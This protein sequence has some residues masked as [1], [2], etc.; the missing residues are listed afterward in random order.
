MRRGDVLVVV[1]YGLRFYVLVEDSVHVEGFGK[2]SGVLGKGEMGWSCVSGGGEKRQ[3]EGRE[4]G[5]SLP[6]CV[7]SFF[8]RGKTKRR[9][10]LISTVR[11]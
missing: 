7:C 6:V 5:R 11:Y 3:R 9:S 2:A 4:G 1:C 8:C 10:M